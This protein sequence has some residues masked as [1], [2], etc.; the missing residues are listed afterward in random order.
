MATWEDRLLPAAYT[1]P[2]GVRYTFSF[3]DL[4][5]D[6]SV[7]GT[8][9][10]FAGFDGSLVVTTGASSRRFPMRCIFHGDDCDT[11]AI[12]FEEAL[13]EAGIGT[14]EHPTRGRIDVV[15]MGDISTTEAVLTAGNQAIVELT[16]Y[17]TLRDVYPR[18][19]TDLASAALNALELA[20][21]ANAAN[22]AATTNT[23]AAS[24]RAQFRDEVKRVGSYTKAASRGVSDAQRAVDEIERDINLVL[25]TVIDD[26]L[27]L[28]FQTIRLIQAP[29]QIVGRVGARLDAALNMWGDVFARGFNTSRD[30][31]ALG[32]V[33]LTISTAV[34]ASVNTKSE[35][36]AIADA[37][38]TQFG[39]VVEWREAVISEDTSGVYDEMQKAVALTAGYLVELSF[40][41]KQE[42]RITTARPR[43]LV[44]LCAELYGST[45][46]LDFF[47]NSNEFTGSEILEI[48]KGREIVYYV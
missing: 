15:P 4:A 43:G 3:E 16:F 27:N 34:N 42:R 46:D 24:F 2:G 20:N 44:E 23:K 18:G 1:T 41:L 19:G 33:G 39:E 26:P 48:P 45:E 8:D 22:F 25:K 14:L 9:Y 37:L 47:I 10:Q 29:G 6:Y 11:E 40:T 35:A 28:A 38:Q 17:E 36:L 5:H 32:S 30:L 31:V 12:A 13:R 7:R 21:A